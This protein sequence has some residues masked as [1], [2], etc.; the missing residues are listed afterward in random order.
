MLQIIVMYLGSENPIRPHDEL[1]EY[2]ITNFVM[3]VDRCLRLGSSGRQTINVQIRHD[4][5][6]FIPIGKNC[7]LVILGPVTSLQVGSSVLRTMTLNKILM[8]HEFYFQSK[9]SVCT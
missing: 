7:T 1:L 3:E 2:C 9:L 5:F 6:Y 8:E 4:Y